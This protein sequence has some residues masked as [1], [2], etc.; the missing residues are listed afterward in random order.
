MKTQQQQDEELQQWIDEIKEQQPV[1]IVEGKKDQAALEALGIKNII[2]L[3]KKPMQSIV[4]GIVKRNKEN[5]GILILT[6]F[7]K[8]GKELAQQL[9]RDFLNEGI[10]ADKTSRRWLRR[11]TRVSHIEGLYRYKENL[12]KSDSK[13]F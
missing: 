4:E 5:K 9:R 8:K 6:D 12:R 7:D 13:S 3:S 11:N 10:I 2:L 1:I